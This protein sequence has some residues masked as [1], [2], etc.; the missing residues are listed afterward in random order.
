VIAIHNNGSTAC[1]VS[2]FP[3]IDI[4]NSKSADRSKNILPLIPGGLGGAPSFPVYANT[5]VYAVLDLNPGGA[6]SGTATGVDEI[7]VLATDNWPNAATQNFP[8][9]GSLVLKPKLGLYQPSVA[10]AI[11][12]MKMA[13]SAQQ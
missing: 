6:T 7:N 1:G 10:D 4:G 2:Y 11:S 8:L 9:D 12:S 5:T 13:D 3:Q